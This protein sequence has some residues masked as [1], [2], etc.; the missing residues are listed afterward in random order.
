MSNLIRE[1]IKQPD[2]NRP[3][4]D[5]STF[6][7]RAKHFFSVVNPINLFA[8][9]RQLEESKAIVQSYKKGQLQNPDLTVDQ[10]WRAKQLYDS[11]YHPETGEKMFLIGRMSAQVPCNMLIT[12]GML[13]FYK[14]TPAVVF[15]H[16]INQT[17]NASVNYTNRSGESAATGS[18]LFQA[19]CCAT[20]G[21]MACA[22]SMNAL[23][24]RL[25]PL[26]GRLVPFCA[27]A[28]ANT[29]NVPMMRSKEFTDGIV[30]EDA[31]GNKLG[32]SCKVAQ[33]AIPQVVIS[34]IG[35]AIPHMV[36]TPI[37]INALDKK[38]W[39]NS[40]PWLVGPIQ[41]TMCGLLLLF[42]TPLC[43]AL[44]PQKASISV[45]KLEPEVRAEIEK[46]PNAPKIV[47]YNKGL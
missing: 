16:W 35:M 22:L 5:Q 41:T 32:S 10:L 12:G 30:I 9:N 20:G 43:C 17:F 46:L 14:R 39:F 23:A 8:S 25:P 24:P 28:L 29:I 18:R 40:R 36:F 38:K 11:A 47:Y 34:R 1:L 15:W 42:A 33:Y 45:D 21:A 26:F 31:D 2:I 6:E 37:F 4:W 27:I 3:R 7:G 44:F 19:Y 13:T